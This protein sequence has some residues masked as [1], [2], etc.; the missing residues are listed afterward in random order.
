MNI[1]KF[2]TTLK[3]VLEFF[4]VS[5]LNIL[6]IKGSF[7]LLNLASTIGNLAGGAIFLALLVSYVYYIVGYVKR[8]HNHLNNKI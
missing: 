8:V 5:A 7:L 6:L 4:I 1:L 3:Y 2:K